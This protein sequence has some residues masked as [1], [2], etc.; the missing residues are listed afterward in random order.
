M[1]KNNYEDKV[2]ELL[3]KIQQLEER[4]DFLSI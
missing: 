3:L 1:K 4:N 2:N